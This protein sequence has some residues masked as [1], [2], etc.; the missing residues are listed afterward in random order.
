MLITYINSNHILYPVLRRTD[1]GKVRYSSFHTLSI[2]GFGISM[3]SILEMKSLNEL[4]PDVLGRKLISVISVISCELT[5][6]SLQKNFYINKCC[7]EGVFCIILYST[8]YIHNDV[9]CMLIV[10]MVVPSANFRHVFRYS[11]RAAFSLIHN[12]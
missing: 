3:K 8:I 10:K 11:I 1:L 6:Y 4:N 5:F 7:P 12:L 9:R 2:D